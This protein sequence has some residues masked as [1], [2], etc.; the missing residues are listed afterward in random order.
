MLLYYSDEQSLY[1]MNRC[2]S[3]MKRE[4]GESLQKEEGK[5]LLK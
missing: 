2:Y 3:K 4:L 5:A 1:R